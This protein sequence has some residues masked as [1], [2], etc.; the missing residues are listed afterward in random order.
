MDE[1]SQ[2]KALQGEIK[3]L[4]R[5]L[6]QFAEKKWKKPPTLKELEKLQAAIPKGA[7]LGE[8][9]DVA[10]NSLR[11]L[12]ANIR[13]ERSEG[14]GRLV[15][16]YIRA[17]KSQGITPIETGGGWRINE[18]ELELKPETS[19]ARTLYN[20]VPLFPVSGWAM[21]TSID[22]LTELRG[23]AL[24]M[25]KQVQSRIPDDMLKKLLIESYHQ[26]RSKRE[27]AGVSHADLVPIV[28]LYR[29]FRVVLVSGELEGQKPDKA[30]TF[31]SIPRWMFLNVLDRY[32]SLV[33]QK[34]SE[35]RLMFQTGS[36]A[37]QARG[38]GYTLGGLNPQQSY[39]V[40]CHILLQ[41]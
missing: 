5:P 16:S 4:I 20:Q 7:S 13:R 21:V 39:R 36:Q 29:M 12:V 31:A 1:I 3:N 38:L 19:Q 23:K 35:G 37:E 9:V 11:T 6:R 2:L 41:S 24:E 27:A 40:Y 18:I 28:E 10:S 17:L 26:A 22:D 30:L 34:E 8:A 15:S 14:F 32:Q 25:L 33:G